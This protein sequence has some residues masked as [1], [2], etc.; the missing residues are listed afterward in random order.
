MKILLIEPDHIM[1]GNYRQ[2]LESA[3][4]AVTWQQSG[5]GA[6]ISLDADMPEL[7]ILELQMPVHNG[8]EFLYE[9]RS[10]PEWHDI[11]VIVSSI[12]PEE[13]VAADSRLLERLGVRHY[14]YKPQTKLRQLLTA[15]DKIA[16]PVQ[17]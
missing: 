6:I 3:G 10:Y 15:V 13:A 8:I 16:A 2:A 17:I 1:A 11:P 12:A 5:Q 7:I 4:H 14:F 9:F